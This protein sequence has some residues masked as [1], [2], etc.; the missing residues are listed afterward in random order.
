MPDDMLNKGIYFY[1]TLTISL[2]AIYYYSSFIVGGTEAERPPELLSCIW[3]RQK[4]HL[5]MTP[6]SVHV[7]C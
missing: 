5:D 3:H 6:E 4:W 2:C 1:M 7:Y